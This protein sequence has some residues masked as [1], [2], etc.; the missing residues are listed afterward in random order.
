MFI[1]WSECW[2]VLISSQPTILDY[3]LQQ[4]IIFFSKIGRS[5]IGRF[6]VHG[7]NSNLWVWFENDGILWASSPCMDKLACFYATLQ[8]N[9]YNTSGDRKHATKPRASRSSES[10]C[11]EPND[12][13]DA[14]PCT[15]EIEP[16]TK[17]IVVSFVWSSVYRDNPDAALDK[18]SWRLLDCR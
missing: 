14:L 18:L 12:V 11:N 15:T 4:Q 13:T 10:W 5:T 17:L 2:N 7:W 8:G 9:A 16:S 6:Q 3:V 1:K